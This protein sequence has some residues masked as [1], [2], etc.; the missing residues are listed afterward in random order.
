M[1]KYDLEVEFVYG[2]V[3]DMITNNLVPDNLLKTMR[4]S[5][6]DEKVITIIRNR[7]AKHEVVVNA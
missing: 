1:D 7:I 2:I 4:F 6:W 3:S 5:E